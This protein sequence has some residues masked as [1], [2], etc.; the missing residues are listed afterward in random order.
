MK[1]ELEPKFEKAWIY[2]NERFNGMD[3]EHLKFC[4]E[5]KPSMKARWSSEE[6]EF[7]IDSWYLINT[8]T[9]RPENKLE[10]VV[11]EVVEE[12]EEVEE[13]VDSAPDFEEMTKK[14]IDVWAGEL[15][16]GLDRRQNKTNMLKELEAKLNAE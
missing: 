16:I 10:E 14:E 4:I 6:L 12:V 2:A 11:E 15:G 5:E 1:L 13:L 7:L 9:C 3:F 8:G